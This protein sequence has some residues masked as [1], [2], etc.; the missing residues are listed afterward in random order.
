MSSANALM[1]PWIFRLVRPRDASA[2]S[3]QM[4][5]RIEVCPPELWPSS[6]GWRAAA[7]RWMERAPWGSSA[8][9]PA[10]RL[11]QVKQ[12]FRNAAA[13][14][15]DEL[16]DGLAD[17]IERA[18]SLREFWHLRSPLYSALAVGFS[19]VEAERRFA[20]LN[21]HFPI[22]APRGTFAQPA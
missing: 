11:A 1:S 14:L 10:N 9:R 6:V 12:E 22:R 8:G 21:R 4:H 13:D 16:R 7:R 3:S 18:R 17:H 20:H 19:Q 15:P 5:S 2:P